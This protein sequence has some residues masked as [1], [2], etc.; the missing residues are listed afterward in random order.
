MSTILPP[1]ATV[2]DVLTTLAKPEDY[3]RGMLENLH[4][5]KREQ[6]SATV[7]IGITGGAVAPNYRIDFSPEANR[8]DFKEGIFGVFDG[9]S[10]KLINWI[11]EAG[12]L[13]GS[14]VRVSIGAFVR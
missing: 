7:R 8:F 13:D 2:P 12:Q 3:V 11:E 1:N 5:C 9:R 10:H 4:E 6:G 14:V